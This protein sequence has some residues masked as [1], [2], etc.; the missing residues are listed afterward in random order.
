MDIDD[1]SGVEELSR[2]YFQL[3]SR[4]SIAHLLESAR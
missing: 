4:V 1:F 3:E 2:V